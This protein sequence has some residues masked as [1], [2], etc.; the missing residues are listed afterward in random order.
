MYRTKSTARL[1][2]QLSKE[3]H[4][5]KGARDRSPRTKLSVGVTRDYP[6]PECT[7][8][9]NLQWSQ[10][11]YSRGRFVRSF[12]PL[13]FSWCRLADNIRCRATRLHAATRAGA[14]DTAGREALLR[15]ILRPPIAQERIEPT[16][17]GMVRIALKRAFPD[18]TVA[19]EMDPL[20]L[21]CRLAMSL[22]SHQNDG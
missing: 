3:P 21:L 18:G 10:I 17:S 5:L 1:P 15:Y 12:N 4:S 2:S 13:L 19:V 8:A 11:D 14:L 22:T 20:P 6:T 9:P 7:T 16:Q